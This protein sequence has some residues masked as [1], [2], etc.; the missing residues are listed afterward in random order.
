MNI[1]SLV[2]KTIEKYNMLECGDKVIAAV[3]GGADS[4]C[5]LH[6]LNNLKNDLK[7]SLCCAH[8]NHGLRGEA[9]DSD[10]AFVKALCVNMGIDFYSKKFDV[11]RL[12]EENKI[13]CEEAGRNVRYSFFEEI[14]TKYG[15]NKVAT[16]HN[17]ND[18]AE[19]VLMRII[20]GTGIDGLAGIPYIRNDGVIRPILDISR[21]QVEEYCAENNL[22]FC[23]DAT[24][25]ENDF[26]R[27]KVRNMLI[28]FIE[29][30]FN[31][32]ISDSLIRL[33][34]SAEEDSKFLKSY[35][36]RLYQ[37]L[38]N[39]IPGSKLNTLHI[40]SLKLLE[41]PILTRILQ[42]A[43]EKSSPA[44]L[45][46]KHICD[47]IE[48]LNKNT[49]ASINL[50]QGLVAEINYGWLTFS[51]P[52][53]KIDVKSNADGF[54]ADIA[55]GDTVCIEALG[56]EISI[57]EENA[58]EYKC[59]INEIAAD[60]DKIGFQPLF[61]R[62]RR[63]GDKIVWFSDGKAK[64]IKNIF[65]DEKIPQKDRNKIPLLA[66]GDEIIAIVGSRVSEKYKITKDSERALV[67]RYGT[68]YEK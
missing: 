17:K 46:K 66:T 40:D 64:K 27:N 68:S 16:A 51:G 37:R 25:L 34:D 67:I 9:A 39:P 38:G 10:E 3:S 50:P 31:A 5:M 57:R 54:F 14:K 33:S 18:N 35:T 6:I 59:K 7:F 58:K 48:L 11:A 4:V 12:A 21:E 36:K 61:L 23:T 60:I 43:A 65:I 56:K 32:K 30:E 63:D 22:E 2:L 24:N 8:I 47:I 52:L 44:K 62:S 15:Y 55:I 28:P 19:T 45:E 29:R 49:G 1:S 42:L 20:R 13:T 26:T 53:D 41:K